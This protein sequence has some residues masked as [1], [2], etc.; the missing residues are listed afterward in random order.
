MIW[1]VDMRIAIYARVS[2]DNGSQTPK[3]Q[4]IPL[5]NFA[6]ALG[7][8]VSNE[9]IDYASGAGIKDRVEFLRLLDDSDRHKHDLILVTALDRLSREGINNTLGYLERLKR[10]GVAVKSLSESWLDTRDEGVAQLLLAIFAWV[11]LQE[12]KRLVERVKLGLARA[13]KEGKVLGRPKG[14]VDKRQR[15]ISGYHLRYAGI[16]RK[17]RTIRKKD[18]YF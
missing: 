1:D 12:R 7:G 8:T 3:N 15:S 5:R 14:S 17:N 9:Y 18:K 13:K 16:K 2:K 6:K 10:N 11:A 4:L